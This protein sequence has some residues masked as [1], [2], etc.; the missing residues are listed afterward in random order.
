MSDAQRDLAA[1]SETPR[2]I[3]PPGFVLGAAT[4]AY[5]IEGA[6]DADGRGASIWD[7][8]SHTP[9][10]TMGG[11]TGDVA[12]DHYNRLNDDLDLMQ[13]LGL[14]AYRF[15]VSWPRIQADGSGPAN[16]LGIDFYSR[17]IDGLRERDITPIATLYHWD[18]PQ[19]LEDAGGWPERD[20]S[21]RFAEYAS[22]MGN[23]LGDRVAMWTTLNEPWCSAF[24][25]YASGEHAPG[26]TDDLAALTASHHLNLAHGLAL[27]A[28]RDSVSDPSA[29]Y[30][31]TLNFHG[32]E[33]VDS[34]SPEAIARIDAL[35]HRTFLDPMLNGRLSDRLVSDTQG[36]TD[37]SFVE[38]GDLALINQPIDVLGLNYYSSDEVRMRD[39][40]GDDNPTAWPGS[41]NVEF[42]PTRR[43]RTAMG[44]GIVPEGLETLL[45]SLST[46]FPDLPLMVTENGAAF[47]DV[48]E[49]GAVHDEDRVAYLS[50][51][52]DAALR[53][54]DRG[55]D[56]RG[57]LVWSLIDNFEWALGYAKRF[58]IIRVDY[59]TL[60]R[61]VKDSG[62]WLADVIS[63]Q[64]RSRPLVEHN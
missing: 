54:I 37:W 9:G 48:E 28:L 39:H 46:E 27:S 21:Y 64:P 61:T 31:V 11:D 32:L 4:A 23:A 51:H 41:R 13:S 35:T 30:S 45:V 22:I 14:Q 55:V 43:S 25:G 18:L 6:H 50:Q 53:A 62:T 40:A 5:Q 33:P 16:L 36:I 59:E 49:R 8:F 17:L 12:A 26:R 60:E 15:S 10:R 3:F 47:D 19:A 29:Q 1:R 42:V 56:L 24:M 44:W 63:S 57:Y 34:T 38:P 58:G 7:V 52:F 20:T 2:R